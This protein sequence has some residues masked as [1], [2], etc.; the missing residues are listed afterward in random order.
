[1]RRE[2]TLMFVA[3]VIAAPAIAQPAAE[4]AHN[5]LGGGA[6]WALPYSGRGTCRAFRAS[7]VRWV[8]ASWGIGADVRWWRRNTTVARFAF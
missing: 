7:G 8:L 1:M 4:G 3:L 2:T 5:Q 6:Q